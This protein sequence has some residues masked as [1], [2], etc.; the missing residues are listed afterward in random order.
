MEV[1][2]VAEDELTRIEENPIEYEEDLQSHLLKA[3]GAEI[4]G[5]EIM[6]ISREASPDAEGGYF[7]ILGV[8]ESGDTVIVELKRGKTPR[9]VVSQALEYAS[10]VRKEEYDRLDERFHAFHRERGTDAAG[11]LRTA[12][13]E[14]FDLDAGALDEDEFNTSIHLVVLA[15]EFDDLTLNMADLLRDHDLDVVCVR[16][17]TFVDSAND[18]NLLTT[19]SVR[20]PLSKEPGNVEGTTATKEMQ[21]AFW[22]QL[23]EKIDK[24]SG[25]DLYTTSAKP[26]SYLPVQGTL[27]T[28]ADIAL[29]TDSL[30]GHIQ[31]KLHLRDEGRDM[32]DRLLD[33]KSDIE[34]EIGAELIWEPDSARYEQIRLTRDGD[35]TESQEN[36][37]EY[38]DW[39]IEKWK[40]FDAVFGDYL[41]R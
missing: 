1:Y 6:Y 35:I 22:N 23:I 31:V 3:D 15:A 14:F 9:R 40:T 34:D 2:T 12:H 29:G 41:R 25:A 28:D 32:Y 10:G 36:W 38:Q 19:E 8:D 11:S 24:Q 39:L 13:T 20:R 21:K 27:P 4:G 16:H 17:Q 18:L 7:D 37:D 26:R 30:R 33:Y 5:M